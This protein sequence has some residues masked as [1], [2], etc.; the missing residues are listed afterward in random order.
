[1]PL[2]YFAYGSNMS[3]AQMR[4][5]CPESVAIGTGWLSDHALVF[6]RYSTRRQSGAASIA[7]Q[8]GAT[9]WGV[10]YSTTETDL[11]RLDV[12]EGFRADRLAA[13]NNYNRAMVSVARPDM[14]ALACVTYIARPEAEHVPPSPDYLQTIL[15]GAI[16]N[17]LPE[18]YV[19]ALRQEKPA[20]S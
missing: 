9:V 2:H 8:P 15:T 6:P 5:R 20:G 3:L 19:Q 7:P 1:M 17:A 4:A 14:D 13:E 12:F 16:E 10:I 11:A 18:A